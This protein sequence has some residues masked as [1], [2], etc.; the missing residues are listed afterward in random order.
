MI[1]EVWEKQGLI[2][3]L[4]QLPGWVKS[5]AQHPTVVGHPTEPELVRIY[6]AARTGYN[7]SFTVYAD[8]NLEKREL[9]GVSP[10][11]LISLGE[12]GT[13]DECGMMPSCIEE[14]GGEY[15]MYYFGIN[16][17][18]NLPFRNSVGLARSSDQGHTFTRVHQGPI[19]DRQPNIPLYA[20]CP[21]VVTENKKKVMY[22]LSG[23]KWEKEDTK[24]R[25]YY[26]IK[27]ASQVG[28]LWVAHPDPVLEI[29]DTECA[30]ARPQVFKLPG[31]RKKMYFCSRWNNYRIGVATARGDQVFTRGEFD[32]VG[33]C[34]FDDEM[35]AYPCYYSKNGIE[36]MFYNGNNFGKEGILYA[37]RKK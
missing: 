20:S 14:V 9:V 34:S 22:F 37:I 16:Q 3:G 8:L 31:G 19:L 30:I 13:F 17:D 35:Q 10:T 11:P 18:I 6:F 1:K 2:L 26:H 21:W 36:Y 15:L 23:I 24:W 29:D 5:H 32:L 27:K 33:N 12:P 25:S 28:G 4:P 7:K